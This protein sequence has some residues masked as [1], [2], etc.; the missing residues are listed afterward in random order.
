[1]RLVVAL[2]ILLAV[3]VVLVTNRWLSDRFTDT[4]RNRAE[5]R[6]AL[7]TGN[8]VSELQRTSVV[9][10]LLARDPD[11]LSALARATL[12][13]PSAKLIALQSE[14]AVASI[15]LL[16]GDG[17]VVGS[18]NRNLLGTTHRSS[19]L[20]RRCAARQGHHL[21]RRQARGGRL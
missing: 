1:M 16:D 9:P 13:P 14:I 6:L 4:T 17:R 2:L 10:L 18:T 19:A 5:V 12:P 21:Y 20:F 3:A 7:Y 15:Q 8:L 11:L